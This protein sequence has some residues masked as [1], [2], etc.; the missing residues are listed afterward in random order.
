M[1]APGGAAVVCGLSFFGPNNVSS[2]YDLLLCLVP[3]DALEFFDLT[4]PATLAGISN[5][6]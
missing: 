1:A 3:C 5:D 4:D 2:T 6:F